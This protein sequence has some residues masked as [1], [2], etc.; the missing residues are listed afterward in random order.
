MLAGEAQSLEMRRGGSREQR[1]SN[2]E[3]EYKPAKKH[4]AAAAIDRGKATHRGGDAG[5]GEISDGSGAGAWPACESGIQMTAS[6]S[7]RMV[8]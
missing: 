7:G 3:H 6:I 4:Q 5:A 2:G 1:S 8:E